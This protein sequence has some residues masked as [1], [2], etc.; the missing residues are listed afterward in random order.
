MEKDNRMYWHNFKTG[1]AEFID[2][3]EDFTDYIPQ[4]PAAQGMYQV[5]L[6]LGNEPI[7]AAMRVLEASVGIKP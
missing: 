4:S 5:L 2:T 3:P 1:Q 7:K 6:K